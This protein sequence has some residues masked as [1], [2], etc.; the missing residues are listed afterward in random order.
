MNYYLKNA[1]QS[2]LLAAALNCCNRI[3]GFT[4]ETTLYPVFLIVKKYQDVYPALS[5]LK[6]IY[7]GNAVTIST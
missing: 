7:H 3:D 1:L 4:Y 5:V 2:K 6:I